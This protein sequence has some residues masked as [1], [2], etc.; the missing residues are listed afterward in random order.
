MTNRQLPNLLLVIDRLFI[1]MNADYWRSFSM[2]ASQLVTATNKLL[3]GV[4][5]QLA[6]LFQ[7]SAPTLGPLYPLN[8]ALN[9]RP[10]PRD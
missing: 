9:L 4:R 7:A 1:Q 6:G 2:L 8:D 3:P 10:R 5:Q